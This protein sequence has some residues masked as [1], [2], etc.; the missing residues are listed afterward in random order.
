MRAQEVAQELGIGMDAIRKFLGNDDITEDTVLDKI[1]IQNLKREYAQKQQQPVDSP[2]P[3]PVDRGAQ[4]VAG[5]A[6][7][8][9]LNWS[10]GSAHS[11]QHNPGSGTSTND[12][13]TASPNNSSE[14]SNAEVDN[15]S[16]P[17]GRDIKLGASQR[18][19]EP[20]QDF[21]KKICNAPHAIILGASA[22]GKSCCL[23]IATKAMG[24]RAADHD[25]EGTIRETY[26]IIKLS[27]AGQ[28]PDGTQCV[29][30]DI[31][32]ESFMAWLGTQPG[33]E[34]PD[35]WDTVFGSDFKP[36][37]ITDR[38]QHLVQYLNHA[39]ALYVLL[40]APEGKDE[41]AEMRVR[42]A[43]NFLAESRIRGIRNK[44]VTFL[45]VKADKLYALRDATAYKHN[46]VDLRGDRGR[47]PDLT[48]VDIENLP[49]MDLDAWFVKAMSDDR[50]GL[51][52]LRAV[53]DREDD[54]EGQAPRYP[55][56]WNYA[57]VLHPPRDY[58]L[59]SSHAQLMRN[60]IS[61]TSRVLWRQLSSRLTNQ[62]RSPEYKREE[63]KYSD[64]IKSAFSIQEMHGQHTTEVSS[65]RRLRITAI[66]TPFI[67]MAIAFF[68][69][70]SKGDFGQRFYQLNIPETPIRI[71]VSDGDK[72]APYLR[73]DLKDKIR[74]LADM[75]MLYEKNRPKL[76]TIRQYSQSSSDPMEVTAAR[77]AG[78]TN[79]GCGQ[80]AAANS[81]AAV[82]LKTM[83]EGISQGTP[84]FPEVSDDQTSKVGK[85]SGLEDCRD[86]VLRLWRL[87]MAFAINAANLDEVGVDVVVAQVKT[88]GEMYESIR[89]ADPT[90][91]G[92][93]NLENDRARDL[94][95]IDSILSSATKA[96]DGK[97]PAESYTRIPVGASTLGD[98]ADDPC[99]SFLV[100]G[101]IHDS[102]NH[103]SSPACAIYM[104]RAGWLDKNGAPVKSL[105]DLY[106]QLPYEQQQAYCNE[107]LKNCTSTLERWNFDHDSAKKKGWLALLV[108][109]GPIISIVLW[110][111]R[112]RLMRFLDRWPS[113]LHPF[114]WQLRMRRG[115]D[116]QA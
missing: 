88:I 80:I 95:L 114:L 40:L 42:A 43:A 93:V 96:A 49:I 109:L 78:G 51:N 37:E 108:I 97:T 104:L 50:L 59:R 7:P 25:L 79:F 67:L 86:A 113:L 21:K 24:V 45:V 34:D 31:A 69:L 47:G 11:G 87:R 75:T 58:L 90:L 103:A 54:G 100:D 38:E 36:K 76:Y 105:A 101:V 23:S 85:L 62:I 28:G 72:P 12:A 5:M 98:S 26:R 20:Y 30:V 55:R 115:A 39:S 46:G 8:S 68:G 53:D 71:A 110:F 94:P 111:W 56:H 63:K 84:T 1:A 9:G 116:G 14:H 48:A 61:D 13:G 107:S 70:L 19:L 66:A 3:Q 65:E 4:W 22:V 29:L 89:Q 91:L 2:A 44:L 15:E 74:M 82:K 18:F 41:T 112:K 6:T 64:F 60:D 33:G 35:N 27:Q 32:G 52:A 106:L 83:L 92:L 16:V 102:G 57:V 81:P 77:K 17:S 10:Y 99:R 73:M